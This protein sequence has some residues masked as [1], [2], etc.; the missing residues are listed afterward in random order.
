MTSEP[1]ASTRQDVGQRGRP[2]DR[3]AVHLLPRPTVI[4]E[5][6]VQVLMT[7]VNHRLT[8]Y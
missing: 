1:D 3:V 6:Q 8:P 2:T 5:P 4:E 7:H